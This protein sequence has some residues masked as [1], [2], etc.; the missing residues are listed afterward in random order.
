[1]K[2]KMLQAKRSVNQVYHVFSSSTFK[3]CKELRSK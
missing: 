2:T 3:N 1:M